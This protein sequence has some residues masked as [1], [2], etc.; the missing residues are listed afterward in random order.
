MAFVYILQSKRNGHFYVGSTDH[1]QQRMKQHQ[2]GKIR[3]TRRLLPVDLVL[4]QQCSDIQTAKRVERKIKK[5]K[6]RDYIQ[7]IVLDG[8]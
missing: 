7:K 6:R 5:F 2:E 8:T 4:K 1:F 3:T